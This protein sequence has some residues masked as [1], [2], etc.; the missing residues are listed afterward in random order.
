M[1]SKERFAWQSQP[2]RANATLQG[3]RMRGENMRRKVQELDVE[4]LG[5]SLGAAEEMESHV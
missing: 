5:D 1:T 3:N 2:C 4:G